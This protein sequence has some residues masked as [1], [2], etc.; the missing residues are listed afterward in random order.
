MR[1]NGVEMHSAEIYFVVILISVL[2]IITIVN[3]ARYIYKRIQQHR[4]QKAFC[5]MF[6][7]DPADKRYFV[8]W[9]RIGQE[10]SYYLGFPQWEVANK[11][12]S[13]NK[14]VKRN[15][16][17]WNESV[18]YVD[19]FV[20]TA[21]NPDDLLWVVHKLRGQGIMIPRCE[22][23]EE[24]YEKVL[25]EKYFYNSSKGLNDIIEYFE[26]VPTQ[27]E[28]LCAS[29][30]RQ[31]GYNTFVTKATNDGGYDIRMEKDGLVCLVECKCYAQSHKIGRPA[32]QKLVGANATENADG[33]IFITT[34]DYSP[35]AVAYAEECDVQLVNGVMLMDLLHEAG[36]FMPQE[37][38]IYPDEWYLYTEDLRWYMPEDIYSSIFAG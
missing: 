32:I 37:I 19:A 25:S 5:E 29:A 1:T 38:T 26:S 34:S 35:N 31:L 24:K 11:D 18:L 3:L 2:L 22:E 9:N 33:L 23:E 16:I 10:N 36:M 6:S 12:G 13:C 17:I 27:F 20:V 8:N 28:N 4:A 21:Y 7:L 14:R 30:Y 15:R